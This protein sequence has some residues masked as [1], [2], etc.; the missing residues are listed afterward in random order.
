MIRYSSKID[1]KQNT[2]WQSGPLDNDASVDHASE[3]AGYWTGPEGA[4][5]ATE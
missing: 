5:G 4:I 3:N 2:V 1:I